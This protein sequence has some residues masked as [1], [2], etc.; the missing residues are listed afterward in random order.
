MASQPVYRYVICDAISGNQLAEVQ[1][2]GVDHSWG[3]NGAGTFKGDIGSNDPKATP[4]LLQAL[5]RDILV[6]RDEVPVFNGP[7]IGLQADFQS[8]KVTINASS[9][10]WWMSRRTMELSL[11]FVNTDMGVIFDQILS[12]VNGKFSGDVRLTKA[13]AYNNTGQLFTISYPASSRKIAA[14]AI[15]DLSQVYPGFD[16]YISLRIDPATGR[17]IREYNVYAP[18]KG[19][20][21][22]QALTASNI[23][24]LT[25]TD[26]GTRVYNRVHEMGSGQGNTQLL[27]SRS[28]YEPAP[29]Y[30]YGTTLNGWTTS[31]P[32]AINTFYGKDAPAYQV[33][34][35]A[36]QYKSNNHGVGSTVEF[37]IYSTKVGSLIGTANNTYFYFGANASGQGN[38]FCPWATSAT[39]ACSV[40]T[41]QGFGAP[42]T[43]TVN[44]GNAPA[45]T[46]QTWYHVTIQID[47]ATTCRVFVDDKQ[48]Y[49]YNSVNGS[50]DQ[51]TFPI[52]LQGSYFGFWDLTPSSQGLTIFDNLQVTG[53][54]TAYVQPSIP[55]IER[56]ISRTDISDLSLLSLYA[57]AD[58]Y[59][60]AYPSKTYT[61]DFA[62]SNSLPYA[63]A[64]PGD[65]VL[66]SVADG[67]F[68]VNDKKRIVNID[69]K[70]DDSGNE[71]VTFQFNDTHA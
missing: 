41:T 42:S 2:T 61:A 59:L 4:D 19:N 65:T 10:W 54:T 17:C 26:D 56:V 60:G 48:M 51:P 30:D 6:L 34:D 45:M 5:S 62:P 52:S 55:Y 21:I 35:N 16:W 38:A 63:F 70:V 36:F 25:I 20:P 29:Y 28:S 53:P 44:Y 49:G 58:L 24:G 39:K 57:T 14:D 47:T 40:L 33:A 69:T 37:D 15:S 46:S 67:F 50:Y 3:L 71:T 68:Q 13:A 9:P 22:D 43:S 8:R 18:F 31:G 7:I 66:I 23:L 12:T 32:C 1:L 27:I 11:D 64:T